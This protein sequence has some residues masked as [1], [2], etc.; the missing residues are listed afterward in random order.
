MAF[1]LRVLVLGGSWF[2]PC[3][4][5]AAAAILAML[6]W[7]GGEV[8]A[9]AA[10]V[11]QS[12]AEPQAFV[13]RNNT[14]NAVL[15]PARFDSASQKVGIASAPTARDEPTDSL[16]VRMLDWG[17]AILDRYGAERVLL[18]VVVGALVQV[19]CLLVLRVVGKF[20]GLAAR[21]LAWG[22]GVAVALSLLDGGAGLPGSASES[23]RWLGRLVDLVA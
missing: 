11:V 3:A 21:V 16:A 1:R 14:D 4:R 13:Q 7:Q 23:L 5:L 17:R 15:R 6:L 19:L 20:L 10:E 2:G 18:V 12:D 8:R 22:L 9:G